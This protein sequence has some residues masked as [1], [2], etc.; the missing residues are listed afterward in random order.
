MLRHEKVIL[1]SDL[2]ELYGVTTC[3]LNEAVQRNL[4]RFPAD[5]MFQLTEEEQESLLSQNAIA[6]NAESGLKYPSGI[7]NGRGGRRTLPYA[8]TE[9]GVAMLSSV[10]RMPRAVESFRIDFLIYQLEDINPKGLVIT[11]GLNLITGLTE[12]IW[13]VISSPMRR[14]SLR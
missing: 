14:G 12:A 8:F 10:L 3:R 6:K 9:Q 1:D 2:A 5:F 11:K 4:D 7:S 13:V